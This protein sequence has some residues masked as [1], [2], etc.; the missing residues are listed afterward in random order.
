M[1]RFA[2]RPLTIYQYLDPQYVEALKL[3][4]VDD[5]VSNLGLCNFDTEHMEIV[6][7]E[8]IKIQTNQ[9]QVLFFSS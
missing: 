4:Q 5:R 2:D 3:L 7:R 9:V 8:G 6:L 1:H